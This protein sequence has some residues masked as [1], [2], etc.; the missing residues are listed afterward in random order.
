[1]IRRFS[2]LSNNDV[3]EDEADAFALCLLMPRRLVRRYL[4]FGFSP[5]QLEE[6]FGVTPLMVYHRLRM[7]REGE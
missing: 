4:R 2:I 3:Q 5:E 1:M 6:I 7:L